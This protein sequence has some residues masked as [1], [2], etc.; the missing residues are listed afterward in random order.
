MANR[1]IK[2]SDFLNEVSLKGNL[3]IPGED[4]EKR[5]DKYLSDVE[6]RAGERTREITRQL[7]P[8]Q[9]MS[10]VNEAKRIQKPY[11]NELAKLAEDVIRK[12]Y[13][14][15]L[16]GVDLDIKFPEP[17]ENKKIMKD[18]P[19]K[20]EESTIKELKDK[21]IIDEIQRRKIGKNLVQGAAKNTKLILNLDETFDGFVEI[22]GAEKA[23]E[24]SDLLNKITNASDFYDWSFPMEQQLG[25][26]ERGEPAGVCKIEWE[27]KKEDQD[28]EAL[29]E[30]LKSLEQND[31]EGAEEAQEEIL[32]D[33]NGV[34]I[35]AR[36]V[37]YAMLL[38]ETVKGIWNLT[39]SASIPEDPEIASKVIMNTDTLF[40]ELEDL[41]YGPYIEADF[42]DFVNGFSELAPGVPNLKERVFGRL[43]T[44]KPASDFLEFFRAFLNGFVMGNQEDLNEAEGTI[45]ALVKDISEEWNTYQEDL[46]EYERSVR[47]YEEYQKEMAGGS[48]M[49]PS[50]EQPETEI[51]KDETYYSNLSKKDLEDELNAAIDS[52]DTN[53]LKLISKFI[54]ESLKISTA[55]RLYPDQGYPNLDILED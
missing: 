39:L 32:S 40:D 54:S 47:E 15:I 55:R 33:V 46:K 52:G 11:L 18:V 24:Y 3:G 43:M 10:W 50:E 51:V 4:P 49:T 35:I 42:R 44:M 9:I 13:G 38:H 12:Y 53:A 25:M 5:G 30:L 45:K 8:Q 21:E 16:D 7:N 6:R 27:D 1:V 31:E 20:P 37:D 17:G 34:K 19:S 26:W 2:F 14:S 48:V 23:R 28:D 41:R 29:K 36:G 22:M